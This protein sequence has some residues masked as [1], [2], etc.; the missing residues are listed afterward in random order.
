MAQTIGRRVSEREV[1]V[2]GF[3]HGRRLTIE[4]PEVRS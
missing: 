1:A 3:T 4:T 2:R